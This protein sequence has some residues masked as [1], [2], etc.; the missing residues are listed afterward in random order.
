[1]YLPQNVTWLIIDN[2]GF[3]GTIPDLS[4][5]TSLKLLW[6]HTN[7]LTGAIPAGRHAA[8]ATWTT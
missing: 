2:N 6:L 8:T 4:G 3:S 5:L 7:A 1:M